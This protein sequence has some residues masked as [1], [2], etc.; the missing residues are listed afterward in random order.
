MDTRNQDIRRDWWAWPTLQKAEARNTKH[1]IRNKSKCSKSKNQ[2]EIAASACGVLAMTG[3][4][5]LVKQHGLKHT[6]VSF[7]SGDI[8]IHSVLVQNTI[9]LNK[10]IQDLSPLKL[11]SDTVTGRLEPDAVSDNPG[12]FT[13]CL[14]RPSI[15]EKADNVHQKCHYSQNIPILH[16]TALFSIITGLF[17]T[18][19]EKSTY[20]GF[21]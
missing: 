15:L 20:D 1:E 21:P 19:S 3:S 18:V 16:Q 5:G 14:L 7:I 4:G 8:V 12:D 2:N 11:H 10:L 17:E 6:L 13:V 9:S